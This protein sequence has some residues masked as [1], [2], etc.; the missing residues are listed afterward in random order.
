MSSLENILYIFLII[1]IGYGARKIRLVP[2]N[3][4]AILST[5]MLNIAL[6]FMILDNFR[7]E[8]EREMLLSALTMI[9]VGFLTFTAAMIL[10]EMSKK[11]WRL[12]DSQR[13][14]YHFGMV[15]P[16]TGFIGLP[17]LRLTYGAQAVFYGTMVHVFFLVFNWTYG[18][19]VYTRGR[20]NKVRLRN[21]INPS[22]IA[23]I[24]GFLMFL[25]SVPI[26][27]VLGRMITS[28]GSTATP[29][30]MFVIGLMLAE[31]RLIEL[32]TS[33][34]PVILAVYRNLAFPLALMFVLKL[35]GF[36]GLLLIVP[37]MLFGMPLA[38]NT[39]ILAQ[40]YGADYKTA[41]KVVLVSTLLAIVTLPILIEVLGQG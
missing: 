18:V 13:A 38:A 21:M 20:G 34:K 6:P 5:F 31:I 14:S 11:L 29:L 37:V 1:L 8:F 17:V 9:L 4:R 22:L 15:L 10:S 33:V 23:V 36:S 41:T 26:P 25:L 35:L 24:V 3:A 12:P 16:N 40:G 30:T 32:F 2:E 19:Y 28:I 39:V 7:F 27:E